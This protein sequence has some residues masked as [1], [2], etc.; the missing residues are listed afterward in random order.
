MATYG[1]KVYLARIHHWLVVDAQTGISPDLIGLIRPQFNRL[2][3]CVHISSLRMEFFQPVGCCLK[4][5]LKQ[6]LQIDVIADVE[7]LV[8]FGKI[9]SVRS[10]IDGTPLRSQSHNVKL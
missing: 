7:Y 9:K 2:S 1:S 6:H 4:T 5:G 8:Q 3:Q 10:D